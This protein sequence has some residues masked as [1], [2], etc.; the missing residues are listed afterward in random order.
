MG[1]IADNLNAVRSQIPQGVRLV[2]VSKFKPV[3]ALEEAYNAGQRLFGENRPLEMASKA[4]QLPSDIEW[5]FIG[6]L[7]TNKIRNIIGFVSMIE[8]V[9]SLHLLQA[10]DA[11]ARA[12]GRKVDCLLEVH[13]A[14][15]Q[16]KGGFTPDEALQVARDAQRLAGVNICGIMAM[17]TFTDDMEQ[18]RSEFA[19][20]RA[21]QLAAGLPQLSMGM[22]GDWR[23]AVEEG[24]T[25]VRIGSA[26]FGAR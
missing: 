19:T 1:I 24:S 18:V 25:I 7:Q 11:A 5:H 2:A 21:V 15:E 16:S 23:I 8:S 6:H 22:S 12:A 14:R 4:Q 3:E 9:D 13:V 20:A 10:V 17:A 26:I